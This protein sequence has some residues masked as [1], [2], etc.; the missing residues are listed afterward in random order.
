MCHVLIIEDEWLIAEHISGLA[1]NGGATSVRIAVTE[2]EAVQ[3]AREQRPSIIMSDVR[4]L[5]G[6]GPMAVIK[7][8]DE[9]GPIPVIFITAT[10]EDCRPCEPSAVVLTKPINNAAVV[11]TFR[12]LAPL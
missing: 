11:S 9:C 3:A 2:C 8:L 5:E 6:S 7:I 4:L 1:E 10:P 12:R